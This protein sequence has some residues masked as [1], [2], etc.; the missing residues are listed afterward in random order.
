MAASLKVCL[1]YFEASL[2]QRMMRNPGLC[3]QELTLVLSSFCTDEVPS[4]TQL[5]VLSILLNAVEWPRLSDTKSQAKQPMAACD[6][7]VVYRF[8][9]RDL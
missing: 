1:T 9:D 4:L 3:L 6:T 2:L 7:S 8:I 5:Q